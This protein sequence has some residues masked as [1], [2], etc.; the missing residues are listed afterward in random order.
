ML[1]VRWFA[2][3][4]DRVCE[5]I[6]TWTESAEHGKRSVFVDRP[7]NGILCIDEGNVFVM[8]GDGKTVATY[9]DLEGIPKAA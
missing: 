5:A 1:T 2:N 6:S 8:N 4:T 7:G 3:G 9:N